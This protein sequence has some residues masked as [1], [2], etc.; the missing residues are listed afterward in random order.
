M[1][2]DW[3]RGMPYHPVLFVD[4]PFLIDTT[5]GRFC[6]YLKAMQL[7]SR[8]LDQPVWNPPAIEISN[9]TGANFLIKYGW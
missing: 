4:N 6:G 1:A 9:N 5:L 2:E 8:L 7:V 3:G